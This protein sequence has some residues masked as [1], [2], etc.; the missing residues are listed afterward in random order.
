MTTGTT[1]T[2]RELVLVGEGHSHVEVLRQ[3]ASRPPARTRITLVA[4]SPTS[5]YSGMVPGLVAGRYTRHDV[6][7]DVAALAA[8]AGAR[9]TTARLTGVD[10]RQRSGE[11]HRAGEP[12]RS[13]SSPEAA[14]PSAQPARR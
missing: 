10:P 5:I 14:S 1:G 2:V 7:I 4:Q 3:F 9:L 12:T 11:R 8:R 13:G 6:E